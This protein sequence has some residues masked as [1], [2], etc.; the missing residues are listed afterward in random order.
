MEGPFEKPRIDA[1]PE[2]APTTDVAALSDGTRSNVGII[3]T[4]LSMQQQP[5]LQQLEQQ[6][7]MSKTSKPEQPP[8][9]YE[10]VLAWVKTYEPDRLW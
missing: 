5:K 6:Q 8:S 9:E 1:A 7:Q 3:F 4:P 2:H 10:Q